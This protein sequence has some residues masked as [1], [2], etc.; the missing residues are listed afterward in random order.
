M[1]SF[2]AEDSSESIGR[3]V[4][5]AAIVPIAGQPLSSGIGDMQSYTLPT[6]PAPFRSSW[7]DIPAFCPGLGPDLPL[8]SALWLALTSVP[9][10]TI[11]HKCFRSEIASSPLSSHFKPTPAPAQDAPPHSCLF[12]TPGSQRWWQQALR[13]RAIEPF[14][15]FARQRAVLPHCVGQSGSSPDASPCWYAPVPSALPTVD[16]F[17][18]C[19][20]CHADEIAGTPAAVHFI[21][22]SPQHAPA[23]DSVWI[24]DASQRHVRALLREL[25]WGECAWADFA[26]GA[27]TRLHGCP[28]CPGPGVPVDSTRRTWYRPT[29]PPIAHGED[30][31]VVCEA[32]FLDCAA[33][34]PA[35]GVVGLSR[36]MFARVADDDALRFAGAWT[37]DAAVPSVRFA[38]TQAFV[39]PKRERGQTRPAPHAMHPSLGWDIERP[40]SPLNPP[41]IW[42][43]ALQPVLLP[44]GSCALE[45]N[46]A[47]PA[48]AQAFH[49]QTSCPTK[50]GDDELDIDACAACFNGIVKPLGFE[51]RFLPLTVLAAGARTCDFGAHPNFA[52]A[53]AAACAMRD[54]AIFERTVR[55]YVPPCPRENLAGVCG[56]RWFGVG[57]EFVCC[58]ACYAEVVK[59]SHLDA[60]IGLRGVREARPLACML[61][62]PR[63]RALFKEARSIVAL[64]NALAPRNDVHARTISRLREILRRRRERERARADALARAA[65]LRTQ[66]VAKGT[67]GL[68][69]AR[70]GMLRADGEGGGFG[71]GEAGAEL[72][73]AAGA[74]EAE[75][76][77]IGEAAQELETKEEEKKEE[78]EL[79]RAWT[80][81]E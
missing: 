26:T 14:Q 25:A 78:E 27:Q 29:N 40:R 35:L 31:P 67:E 75:A 20:A 8:P 13:A 22:Y 80:E 21:E 36:K 19:A 57:P 32:C 55:E 53:L 65:V 74:L 62:S 56:L 11:C 38:M 37:C 45:D 59:G 48:G 76:R 33:S 16:D 68:E 69:Q 23:S 41:C 51:G 9:N 61:Y 17:L 2:R 7:P 66:A 15:S 73:A 3:S 39:Q 70:A 5:L 44:G 43:D 81:V 47:L 6:Y 54:P 18:V 49:Y 63:T 72:V 50:D 10:F 46:H 79:R 24:C 77:A 34:A 28:P 52:R 12:S 58:P 71:A 1:S 30:F 42:P 64:A 4:P 60:Q